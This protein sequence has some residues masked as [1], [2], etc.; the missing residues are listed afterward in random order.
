MRLFPIF[1]CPNFSLA[2]LGTETSAVIVQFYSFTAFKNRTFFHPLFSSA[3]LRK[4]SSAGIFQGKKSISLKI[5][6]KYLKFQ[7]G[8]P[9]I[10]IHF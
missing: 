7:G 4:K 6:E 5:L 8:T 1:S 9:S 3:F 2:S 10:L